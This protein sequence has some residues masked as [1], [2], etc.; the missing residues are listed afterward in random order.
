MPTHRRKEKQY[1]DVESQDEDLGSSITT[2]SQYLPQRPPRRSQLHVNPAS[3]SANIPDLKRLIKDSLL[4]VLL[5][6]LLVFNVFLYIKVDTLQSNTQSLLEKINQLENVSDEKFSFLFGDTQTYSESIKTMAKIEDRI[7]NANNEKDDILMSVGSIRND[8]EVLGKNLTKMNETLNK[9]KSD[10][11]ILVEEIETVKSEQENV[12]AIQGD[13]E[14]V[15]K[16]AENCLTLKDDLTLKADK[17]SKMNTQM[18]KLSKDSSFLQQE[19][20]RFSQKLQE[21]GTKLTEE[22]NLLDTNTEEVAQLKEVTQQLNVNSR[23][24]ND[25][26]VVL[27]TVIA[28]CSEQMDKCKETAERMKVII[29]NETFLNSSFKILEKEMEI[30]ITNISTVNGDLSTESKRLGNLKLLLKT[31]QEKQGE[32]K[33]MDAKLD[34]AQQ[35]VSHLEKDLIKHAEETE[36]YQ[37][38]FPSISKIP[39]RVQTLNE[40][41]GIL[42]I[43]IEDKWV[44]VQRMAVVFVLLVLSICG[45]QFY[46]RKNKIDE[47]DKKIQYLTENK[48]KPSL[49]YESLSIVEQIKRTQPEELGNK[50]CVISFSQETHNKHRRI[51]R[52]S[53]EGRL[54]IKK[55]DEADFV[56]TNDKSVLNIPRCKVLLVFV[57]HNQKDVILE[58]P[59]EDE[60]DIK[61]LT[62]Q[63][64]R[65][66]GADVF[67]IYVGDEG[68]ETLMAGCLYN[69]QLTTVAEHF[70]LKQLEQRN[71]VITCHEKFTITQR[72]KVAQAI[73]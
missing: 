20:N 21:F 11:N 7:K 1:S 3:K 47:M 16:S 2:T 66:I 13:I 63:A 62:V 5:L 50:F 55:M 27:G 33:M 37:K 40:T 58:T 45:G 48:D 14:I 17:I 53:V 54:R 67:V 30:L 69:P 64:C 4:L 26:F 10:L 60:E 36:K 23:K 59:G 31:V 25:S 15:R 52:P 70:E 41:I 38:E 51:T 46:N 28:N 39:D 44:L 9:E 42:S 71:R 34:E 6:G 73:A 68:S 49:Q 72:E 32:I 57:D 12:R 8:V 56:V 19:H 35:S 61:L 18:E 65:K 29:R 43:D 24:L 22:S